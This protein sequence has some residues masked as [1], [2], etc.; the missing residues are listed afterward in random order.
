MFGPFVIS[1]PDL[2]EPGDAAASYTTIIFHKNVIERQNLSKRDV[3]N[4]V[5]TAHD[6]LG[7]SAF[8]DEN[9]QVLSGNKITSGGKGRLVY[10][11]M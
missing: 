5:P 9:T 2:D 4:K 10:S 6:E 8:Y 11:S 7:I 3:E 1:S